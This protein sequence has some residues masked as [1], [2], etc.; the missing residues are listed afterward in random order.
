M[1]DTGAPSDRKAM[2]R[3]DHAGEY[4]ATR[5][6]AGQLAV[7]GSRAAMAPDVERMAG[8]EERHLARFEELMRAH[9]VRPTLLAPLWK[10]AGFALGAL[11]ALA[12]PKTAMAVTAA[13]ET[14]IDRH[15]GRQLAELDADGESDSPLRAAIADFRKEEAEH[16][17]LALASGAEKAPAYPLLSRFVR[18]GC[19]AAIRL[20]TRF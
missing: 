19:R 20:S 17:D 16:R 4:G 18:L 11:S 9:R 2:I 7:M 13:I 8:Q 15:Y 1:R 6:Y 14:E 12:G 5:I 10:H 3:V